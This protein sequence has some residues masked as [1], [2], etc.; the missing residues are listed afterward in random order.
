M[1]KLYGY[2]EKDVLGFMNF[3]K[4]HKGN[5]ST[6]FT[7]YANKVGK[8][9][10]T[11]RNMYYALAKA[12]KEDSAL[13]GKYLKGKSIKV[14][15]IVGFTKE[16][17]KELIKQILTL[18]SQ[19]VSVRRAVYQLA[20]NNVKKALRY[21]N[22][23]RNSLK[24]KG[25]IEEV[26]K[27]IKGNGQ[28]ILPFLKPKKPIYDSNLEKLKEEIDGLVDRISIKHRQENERLKERIALLEVENLK[29]NNLLYE[30]NQSKVPYFMLKE[31]SEK[32]IN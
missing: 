11:I 22:K 27:E 10:G 30:K 29:L 23:Y 17:E 31:D 4:N 12:T 32:V 7:V 20:N 25:L 3:L 8:S 14:N 13:Q 19:G 28:K 2:K 9:R 15:E 1:K 26:V 5:I 16:E 24:N 21:Q 6:A 18:K